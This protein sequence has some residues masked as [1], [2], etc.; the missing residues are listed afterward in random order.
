MEQSHSNM[1]PNTIKN[2]QDSLAKFKNFNKKTVYFV[3]GRV[4]TVPKTS[5]PTFPKL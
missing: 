2:A 4:S 1:L 3:R 5:Q